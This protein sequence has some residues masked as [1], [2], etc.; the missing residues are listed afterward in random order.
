MPTCSSDAPAAEHSSPSATRGPPQL[1]P[2]LALPQLAC[3]EVCALAE[4]LVQQQVGGC[5]S[6]GSCGATTGGNEQE[7]HELAVRRMLQGS[8]SV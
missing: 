7:G 2:L 3:Q 6:D 4:G 8:W 1:L 5:T